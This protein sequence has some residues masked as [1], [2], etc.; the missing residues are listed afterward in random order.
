L[1]RPQATELA[2]NE[3]PELVAAN[4]LSAGA[5]AFKPAVVYTFL[6]PDAINGLLELAAENVLDSD[7]SDI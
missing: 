4:D 7:E 6:K 2:V 1:L 3:L 5:A